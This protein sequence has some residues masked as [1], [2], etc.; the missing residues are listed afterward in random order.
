MNELSRPRDH[1][2][3]GIRYT[4]YDE[5]GL[6]VV[7]Y[8]DGTQTMRPMTPMELRHAEQARLV[9][10]NGLDVFGAAFSRPWRQWLPAFLGLLLGLIA[11]V[12]AVDGWR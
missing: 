10:L 11:V 2:A 6:V 7:T 5:Q 1:H 3:R 12:A 4:Y 9:R 8:N